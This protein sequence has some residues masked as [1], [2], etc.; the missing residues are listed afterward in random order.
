MHLQKSHLP[1]L[2]KQLQVIHWLGI[3]LVHLFI[4]QLGNLNPSL[5]LVS[6]STVTDI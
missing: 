3:S 1:S 2:A 6:P 5:S 4:E